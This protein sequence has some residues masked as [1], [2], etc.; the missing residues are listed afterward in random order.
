[1]SHTVF[2]AIIFHPRRIEKQNQEALFAIRTDYY[3]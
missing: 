3:D 1:M 2:Y